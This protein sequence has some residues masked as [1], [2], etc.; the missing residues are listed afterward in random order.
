M[1]GDPDLVTARSESKPLERRTELVF[2][3]R[4]YFID[5][6]ILVLRAEGV[7]DTKHAIHTAYSSGAKPRRIVFSQHARGSTNW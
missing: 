5:G 7:S 1:S 2:E 6:D 4:T 3:R